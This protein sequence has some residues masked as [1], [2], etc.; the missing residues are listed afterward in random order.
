MSPLPKHATQP[1]LSTFLLNPCVGLIFLVLFLHAQGE[2]TSWSAKNNIQG[3]K[4][5]YGNRQ[6]RKSSKGGSCLVVAFK[7]S[8]LS[9]VLKDKLSTACLFSGMKMNTAS[10]PSCLCFRHRAHTARHCH[11]ILLILLPTFLLL[12]LSTF[13][14]CISSGVNSSKH[15]CL[16]F[17]LPS[18]KELFSAFF[19]R[20]LQRNNFETCTRNYL[21]C[22][23]PFHNWYRPTHQ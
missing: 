17:L 22:F 3:N 23:E 21:L 10:A 2:G 5:I 19:E 8:S 1:V 20:H 13:L 7:D 6:K 12:F 4:S 14:S 15:H 9:E 18:W 16:V 11:T